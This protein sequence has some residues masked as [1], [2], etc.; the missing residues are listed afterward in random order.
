MSMLACPK[1]K[2]TFPCPQPGQSFSLNT[3]DKWLYDH[4]AA[5][6]TN[7]SGT[8]VDMFQFDPGTST[9]DP[10]YGEPLQRQYAGPLTF[11]ATVEWPEGTP[12][13]LE[14]GSDIIW[15]GGLWIPR[16]TIEQ[17]NA[18]APRRG[19]IVRFWSIP[20]FESFGVDNV[21]NV[22]NSGYFFIL[23]KVNDDGH[24]FDAADFSAFRCDLKRTTKFS[25]ERLIFNE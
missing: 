20:F 18:R 9:W 5:E 1:N 6:V 24:V 16:A 3:Q 19:D 23:I 2:V 4:V 13:A 25:P 15:P 21:P 7:I 8:S 12:E 22:P 10:V 14:E 17:A 11:K